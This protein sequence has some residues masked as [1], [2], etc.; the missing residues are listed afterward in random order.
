MFQDFTS[1]SR[2]QDGPPRL[3]ALR[4]A[5]AA[6]AL[7][8]VIVPRADLHQGE[9]VADCDARLAWLTGFTG[10]AGFCIVLPDRA[11]LFVDGRYRVQARAQCAEV[12]Q[13]VPWPDT[14]PADWLRDA[15]PNGAVIAFD[16]WLHTP[17]EIETLERGLAGSRITLQPAANMIDPLWSDR[18]APPMGAVIAYPERLAGRS[19][20]TKRREAAQAL[21]QNG[22]KATV[23]T[24][25]DSICWLLNLRGSDLPRVPVVQALAV[26]HDDGRVDVFTEAAKFDGIPLDDGISLRPRAAF[27]PA[28]RSLT[29][30]VRVDRATAP[31]AVCDILTGAGVPI[32]PMQDPCL[33]PKARKTAAEL[34]GARAAHLRDGAAMAE[35]LCWLDKQS[36]KLLENPDHVVTEIDIVRHL[37]ACRVATGALRDIS[38]D[39]IAGSGPNGAIV[40]YRVTEDSNRRLM[41]GDL[42]LVDSGGQYLDGTT[43][44][45]RTIAI[46]PV[47]TLEAQCFTRVLDGMIAL[48]RAHFPRGVAGGH[49]DALARYPLWLAGLDYDHGTGHG[50]GAYLSVH[51]GPQRLSRISQV[52]LAEGMILS[53]EPGYYRE[54]AFG[55]RLEN[56]VAVRCAKMPG[57][58]DPRDWLGFETLTLA[59]IDRRLI[60]SA[61]LS[62]GARDWLNAYHARVCMS[63]S[64]LVTSETRAWLERACAPLVG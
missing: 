34:D 43:D 57:G 20:A 1:P 23:L 64:P 2:P 9:Y 10:S 50:V 58:A 59:P 30:P 63:V 53:N 26:L 3:A 4:D 8:G 14:R 35:F 15:C 12:F 44:I 51:E 7:G 31:L 27:E 33:G 40:H 48:S 56:L 38:F 32:D 54:G 46:G 42:M 28:L 60:V 6:K 62:A 61:E 16:P 18:P 41:P 47:G 29:G 39:T 25:P 13:I 17:D 24:Q 11:G 36:Q 19:S 49:L 37:E 52:P 22:Q 55:I 45:T 21:V 5:L